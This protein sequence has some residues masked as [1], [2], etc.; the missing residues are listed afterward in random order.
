MKNNIY[1]RLAIKNIRTKKNIYLPYIL[2]TGAMFALIYDIASIATYDGEGVV[3]KWEAVSTMLGVGL[4]ISS[5]FVFIFL[6]SANSYINRQNKKTFG[7]YTVLGMNKSNIRKL[8]VVENIILSLITLGLGLISGTLFVKFI[9]SILLKITEANMHNIDFF[10]KWAFKYLLIVSLIN[11]VIGVIYQSISISRATATQLINGDKKADKVKRINYFISALGIIFLIAGYVMA[12][13][14]E[15]RESYI[16]YYTWATLLVIVGTFY[17]MSESLGAI[18]TRLQKN[19][20]FYYKKS[21]FMPVSSIIFRLKQ[22]GNAL[23]SICVLFT[24]VLLVTASTSA[25]FFSANHKYDVNRTPNFILRL[26]IGRMMKKNMEIEDGFDK[27]IEDAITKDLKATEF[28]KFKDFLALLEV[29]DGEIL[30]SDNKYLSI[31]TT[32]MTKQVY[33]SLYFDKID[34]E[35]DLII[36]SDS[37]ELINTDEIKIAGSNYSVEKMKLNIIKS[38]FVISK[39]DEMMIVCKDEE[40]FD[41]IVDDLSIQNNLNYKFCFNLYGETEE[42]VA[43]IEKIMSNTMKESNY[44]IFSTAQK[45]L[46]FFIISGSL[47]FI[48]ALLSIMLIISTAIIIYYKQISEAQED[49]KRYQILSK[50]GMDKD[51][52][53][54]IINTQVRMVFYL[55]IL[56]AIVHSVFAFNTVKTISEVIGLDKSIYL[57]YS[58]IVIAIIATV[59]YTI[60]YKL[61]SRAYYRIVNAG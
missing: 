22:N 28:R 41:K 39:I 1:L 31:P 11:L 34:S 30:S 10:S 60:I 57:V 49:V 45:K 50:I 61:S 46:T 38:D 26:N 25:I 48:G 21:H 5:I 18:F 58:L 36:Y 12:N 20:N 7:L 16:M 27:K 4:F 42:D 43:N 23:A 3:R 52:I 17:L 40:M 44:T 55:P 8:I 59:I 51:D 19:K 53:K 6:V 47:L 13:I 32:V 37:S 35:K 56:L 15:L 33:N 2:T 29:K 24:G 14:I 9:F 54:K